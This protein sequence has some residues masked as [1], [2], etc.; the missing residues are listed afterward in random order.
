MSIEFNVIHTPENIS[1]VEVS[2]DDKDYYTHGVVVFTPADER[3]RIF[4]KLVEIE[5]LKMNNADRALIDGTV[6]FFDGIK[7]IGGVEA[8][9]QE[10]LLYTYRMSEYMATHFGALAGGDVTDLYQVVG[11]AR[12]FEEANEIVAREYAR[13][14]W[15]ETFR[16]VYPQPVVAVELED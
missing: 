12:S 15:D 13:L 6:Q 1:R 7:H 11:W 4:R 3:R 9:T 16:T 2:T 8:D 10:D 14:E 5:R